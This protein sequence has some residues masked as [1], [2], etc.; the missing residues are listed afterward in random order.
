M[1][2]LKIGDKLDI[3]KM[4]LIMTRRNESDNGQYNGQ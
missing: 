4:K 3:W 1:L 2:K